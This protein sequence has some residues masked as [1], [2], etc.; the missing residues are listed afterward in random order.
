MMVKLADFFPPMRAYFSKVR[1]PAEGILTF[2]TIAMLLM[3]VL[4]SL[5]PHLGILRART[6]NLLGAEPTKL[7]G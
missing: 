4:A 1:R 3:F 7:K 2:I 6:M 5:T